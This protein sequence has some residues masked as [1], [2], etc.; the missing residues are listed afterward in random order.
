ME[1]YHSPWKY[2]SQYPEYVKLPVDLGLD[3]VYPR[4]NYEY[5]ML[6]PEYHEFSLINSSSKGRPGLMWSSGGRA[7]GALGWPWTLNA[8]AGHPIKITWWYIYIIH[9]YGILEYAIYI[10]TYIIY[11]YTCIG[12]GWSAFLLILSM[13]CAKLW[14]PTPKWSPI[15]PLTSLEWTN[16]GNQ[17]LTSEEMLILN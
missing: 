2:D 14:L 8:V 9:S 7:H 17:K 10:Y 4:K 5:N 15:N 13:S 16:H 6:Y 1:I 11:I 3:L 12:V